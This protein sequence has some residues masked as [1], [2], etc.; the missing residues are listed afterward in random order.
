MRSENPKHE[1]RAKHRVSDQYETKM[2]NPKLE[3]LNSKQ[4]QM[5]LPTGRQ[6]KYKTQNLMTWKIFGSIVVKSKLPFGGHVPCKL[7]LIEGAKRHNI[8]E[9]LL[10]RKSRPVGGE[11][12]FYI[13]DL[14]RI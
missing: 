12:H 11:L 3:T 4:T 2:L 14:F 1:I 8:N 9:N 7:R 6:A 5:S 13:L 10:Y